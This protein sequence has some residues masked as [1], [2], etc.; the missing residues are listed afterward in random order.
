MDQYND[1]DDDE[2][3]TPGGASYGQDGN[4]EDTL[5]QSQSRQEMSEEKRA[6]LREIEVSFIGNPPLDHRWKVFY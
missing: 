6:K 5:S 1:V 2:E 3:N 4:E